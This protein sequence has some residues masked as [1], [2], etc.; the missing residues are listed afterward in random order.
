[1]NPHTEQQPQSHDLPFI[2]RAEKLIQVDDVKQVLSS[3]FQ[4]TAF[5]PIGVGDARERTQ[6]RPIS[7]AKTQESHV[8]QIRPNLPAEIAGI[9]WLAMGLLLKVFIFHF[10]QE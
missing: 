2:R 8:L 10:M 4:G 5:D 1:M 7:L 6:Y 3:H 9:H